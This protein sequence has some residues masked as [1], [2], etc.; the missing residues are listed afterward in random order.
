MHFNESMIDGGQKAKGLGELDVHLFATGVCN[1]SCK[2]CYFQA[3]LQATTEM[4]SIE[5]INTVIEDI[6]QACDASFEL[7]GGEL[8]LREDVYDL[9]QAISKHNRRLVTLTTNGCVDI[10]FDRDIFTDF[11]IVRVSLE[12]H[13]DSIQRAIRGV[14]VERPLSTLRYLQEAGANCAVRITIHQG[15]V[16]ECC[17]IVDYFSQR[18][19]RKFFFYEFEP[20]G[21]GALA[22]EK[23][24]VSTEQ[25]ACLLED[26][27]RFEPPEGVECIRV[28]LPKRRQALV[29]SF[30]QRLANSGYRQSYV[31]G[32]QQ[33][34]VRY[35]GRLG[36]CPWLVGQDY[37]AVLGHDVQLKEELE[38]RAITGGLVHDCEF[39]TNF[40]IEW[41]DV[42]AKC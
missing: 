20:L 29:L 26:L 39:C 5:Q 27:V 11:A 12:S 15:N 41:K 40:L 1:L 23:L 6:C 14:D 21:R 3:Q 42:A 30:A 33:L 34:T 25:V 28:S 4:L 19:V 10:P 35:D 24:S 17:E 16:S 31:G 2:H 13:R 38:R 36:T 18:G 8:F 7:E 32:R 22:V 37:F 9:L